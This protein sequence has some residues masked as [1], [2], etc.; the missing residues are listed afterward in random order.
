MVKFKVVQIILQAKYIC[1]V[2]HTL[3]TRVVQYE[4]QHV[5]LSELVKLC[6]DNLQV[7]EKIK[8]FQNESF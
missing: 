4:I 1:H 7:E 3:N 5:I 6:K 8:T 2:L